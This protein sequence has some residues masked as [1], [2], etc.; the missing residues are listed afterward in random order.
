MVNS[1]AS[2]ACA[3]LVGATRA[4]VMAPMVATTTS[5]PAHPASQGVGVP[6][7]PC[8]RRAQ[9]RAE[10][11]SIAA[12][13]AALA[14]V[15]SLLA[16]ALLFPAR[17]CAGTDDA[18]M[19]AEIAEMLAVEPGSTVAEI[20]AGHGEMAVRMAE[21]VGPAGH[22][23]ATEIDPDRV[24]DIQKRVAEAGLAN[25]TVVAATA[26]DTGLPAG[27]CDAAYMIGVYHHMT[28]PAA[29][30]ASLFRSLK[31]GGRLLIND[32]PPTLWLALFKVEG[33]PANRGGHGVSDDAVIGEVTAAG[34]HEVR[35]IAP[36]HAGFFIRHNYCL[37]FRKAAPEAAKP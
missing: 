22:V 21:K 10:S 32:F 28:D 9:H 37:L 13:R 34:F 16:L 36:W 33:V 20:G 31:P 8:H 14:A 4:R 6:R 29:T 25:V 11:E 24:A 23:Y 35:E 7:Q 12:P 27:S 15:A 17:A 5:A 19:A 1:A 26:T 30:D 2:A 3:T 18:A